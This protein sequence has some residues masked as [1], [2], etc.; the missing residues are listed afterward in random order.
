MLTGARKRVFEVSKIERELIA[1]TH[2]KHLHTNE[3]RWGVAD[4]QEKTHNVN[5]HLKK[6]LR[7]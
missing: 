7:N 2:R 6:I 3:S 4:L 5:R 1:G